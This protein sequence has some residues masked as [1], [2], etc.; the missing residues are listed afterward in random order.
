MEL[1]IKLA[2]PI[3]QFGPITSLLSDTI[4]EF[5]ET[6]PHLDKGELTANVVSFTHGSGSSEFLHH[7][8]S[9]T[10]TSITVSKEVKG[11]CCMISLDHNVS[12]AHTS[13]F[14]ILVVGHS[15]SDLVNIGSGLSASVGDKRKMTY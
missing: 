1:S 11:L 2:S 15:A 4:V 9:G 8:W 12:Q 13:D 6:P 7:G 5:G 10:T 14:E 3:G